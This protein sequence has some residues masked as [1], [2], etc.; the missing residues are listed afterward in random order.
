MFVSFCIT[1]GT[2]DVTKLGHCSA[3][4]ENTMGSNVLPR[5]G[6]D[7]ECNKLLNQP[8]AHIDAEFITLN[9]LHD[10]SENPVTKQE[11]AEGTNA[12]GI[13]VQKDQCS[14]EALNVAPKQEQEKLG[15]ILVPNTMK[16]ETVALVEGSVGKN[17]NNSILSYPNIKMTSEQG[18]TSSFSPQK[19]KKPKVS[20]PDN[21]GKKF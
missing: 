6:H 16:D 13:E 5:N 18:K 1:V 15:Q 17:L 2:E 20:E 10:E 19:K 21:P 7:G 3:L 4:L 9:P 14:Q 12:L 11:G 8:G